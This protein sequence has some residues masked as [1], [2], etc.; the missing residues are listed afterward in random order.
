MYNSTNKKVK[1][2][3]KLYV[4]IK[5]VIIHKKKIWEDYNIKRTCVH[6]FT[7]FVFA[8]YNQYYETLTNKQ[9]INNPKI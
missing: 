9:Q 6:K 2:K 1:T 3:I 4:I 7:S 5:Y 8:I